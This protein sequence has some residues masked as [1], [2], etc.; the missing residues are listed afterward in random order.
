MTM[1]TINGSTPLACALALAALALP[2]AACGSTDRTAA[3][4]T[5]EAG[6]KVIPVTVTQNGKAHVF[7]AELA[8]TPEQQ[9]Q[10]L[11]YRK[12]L[13]PDAAMLFPF[14]QPKYA[15]FWMKNTLIPLDI[16]FVRSDGTIDRIAENTVPLSEIPVASGGE[17]AAVLELEGGTAERLG[18][19]E[20]ATVTWTLPTP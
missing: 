20:G 15:S 4:A 5:S 1:K 13:A 12:A 8:A 9:Q 17:V 7:S 10:G 2:L 16:V 3:A 11:M 19:D 14:P 6:L 18:I